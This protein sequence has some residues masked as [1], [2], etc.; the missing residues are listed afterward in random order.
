MQ[1]CYTYNA[2]VEDS[3]KTNKEGYIQLKRAIFI[4][5]NNLV[6]TGYIVQIHELLLELY[7]FS[8]LQ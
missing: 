3:I 7:I 2:K 8:L 6:A 1:Q 4:R 5:I